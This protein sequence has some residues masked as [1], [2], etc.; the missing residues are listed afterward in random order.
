MYKDALSTIKLV[1]MTKEMH[2]IFIGVAA[3]IFHD[4]SALNNAFLPST[5]N[6]ECFRAILVV[7]LDART[8]ILRPRLTNRANKVKK[9]GINR[10]FNDSCI[11]QPII[12]SFEPYSLHIVNAHNV[13]PC[14]LPRLLILRLYKAAFELRT[15]LTPD[16]LFQSEHFDDLTSLAVPCSFRHLHFKLT[17]IAFLVDSD[18]AI[19]TQHYLVVV[20]FVFPKAHITF[21]VFVV[22]V[23]VYVD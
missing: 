4:L 7:T 12:S 10:V 22:I 20:T 3:F 16:L 15:Q 18:I 1:L 23:L 6:M 14:S 21:D 2:L 13:E 8:F 9:S 19:T 5:P 17:P 11:T